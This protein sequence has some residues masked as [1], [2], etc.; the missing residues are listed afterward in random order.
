MGI[1]KPIVVLVKSIVAP[2]WRRTSKAALWTGKIKKY[3]SPISIPNTGAIVLSADPST[4]VV[5]RP[6]QDVVCYLYATRPKASPTVIAWMY[7]VCGVNGVSEHKALSD[8]RCITGRFLMKSVF[9][10]PTV[11]L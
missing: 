5:R 3:S 9:K 1:R 6:W 8:L 10:C 7:D 4:V 2:P 11:L